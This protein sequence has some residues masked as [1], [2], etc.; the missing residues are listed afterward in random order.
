MIN[1][2]GLIGQFRVP[3]PPRKN[4]L[5]QREH[6]PQHQRPAGDVLQRSVREGAGL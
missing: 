6:L 1:G 3:P 4:L 5:A 2:T